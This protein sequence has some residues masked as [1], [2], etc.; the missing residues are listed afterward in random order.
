MRSGG[1]QRQEH[2]AAFLAPLDDAGIGEDLDVARDPRLALGENL[3]QFADRQFHPPQEREDA[4]PRRVRKRLEQ[5]GKGK[6]RA[7]G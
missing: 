3:G 4:Q 6:D 5:V 7:T 2:P 1:G